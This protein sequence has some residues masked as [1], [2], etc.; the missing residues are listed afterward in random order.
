MLEE[1]RDL[2]FEYAELS[3]GIRLSLVPGILDAVDTGVVKIS[4]LHNFCPLP[5]GVNHAAPNIFR[6][7][8]TD[9]R[10]RERAYRQ[11]IQTMEL[12]ERVKARLIVLHMGSIEMRDYTD[13]LVEMVGKGQGNTSRYERLCYEVEERRQE[14]RE[15]HEAHAYEILSF[16]E[17]EAVKRG[18]MLGIENRESLE[19]I[20]FETDFGFL[21]MQ[22]N[23][24]A[25][26]YWHDCGHGQIKE[27][28]GFIRHA[29]HVMGLAE[30]LAGFHIHDVVF[31]GRDHVPPGKGMIDYTS[32]APAVRPEHIKVLELHPAVEPEEVRESFAHMKSLWGEE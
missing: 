22:F 1:I 24:G 21:F 28:I 6:F 11:T 13:K 4:T 17:R 29:E 3:H 2:G 19:E 30:H 15:V 10:E 23:S 16:L 27:N 9:R 25:V 32:L 20:P 5:M 12:A 26:R 7:T 31:P 18:L 14:R 8:S